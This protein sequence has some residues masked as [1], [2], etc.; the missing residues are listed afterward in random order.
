MDCE[1][2]SKEG[3]DANKKE[4]RRY[5]KIKLKVNFLNKLFLT[6]HNSLNNLAPSAIRLS[7]TSIH[8]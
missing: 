3:K 6:N 7:L 2:S 5:V 8:D 4:I 1:W